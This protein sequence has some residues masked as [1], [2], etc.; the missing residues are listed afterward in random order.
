[1][2]FLTNFFIAID[3]LGN[4]IAGGNPDNTISSRVGYYTERY[5]ESAKIPLR[6]RIF[7]NIIN[8]SF[9][10]IDGENHCKEAYFNDAGEE[11]DEGT[12]DI[13]VSIL[14]ILIIVSC[15]FIVILFY[16]L[17]AL[18]VVSPKDIDR[19]A[20]IKQRLQIAEAKLKG[21]YS[22]LNEHH[23]QVD[24]EL[25]EIIEDTETTLK[26]ISKKIEGILKLK[27]RLKNFKDKK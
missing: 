17:Y 16:S 1:M 11:F 10:P 2:N 20:N 21:V 6:W 8:F 26:E 3:Q 27:Y 25:D 14:A 9:Y 7:R 23:I 15:I 19:T 13:A 22:E 5:Y 12:S 24:E 18:G 4:V